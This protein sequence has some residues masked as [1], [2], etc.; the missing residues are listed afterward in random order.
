MPPA[1]NAKGE[2]T[3]IVDPIAIH[4][5][6]NAEGGM[7]VRNLLIRGERVKSLAITLAPRKT[8]NL[9][10]H[11]VKRVG[12]LDGRTVVLVGPTAVPYALYVSRGTE[13]HI[14]RARNVPNLVFFWPKVGKVVAFPQVNHPGTKPN[15]YLLRALSA[16]A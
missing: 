12:K 2:I 14:I 1:L 5:L 8:G 13:P 15:R 7:V 9:A 6:V 11:I 3:V 10:E 16:A 4:E